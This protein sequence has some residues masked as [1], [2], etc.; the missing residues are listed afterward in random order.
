MKIL[1][2]CHE[3]PPIGG[4]Y[5]TYARRL[6][7]E[8]VKRGH[9][10]SVLTGRYKDI[11][12]DNLGGKL[13]IHTVWSSRKSKTHN[14]IIRTFT[15]YVVLGYL[16]ARKMIREERYDV[17]HAFSSIPAGFL[18]YLLKRRRGPGIVL[19]IA[20]S[21]VPYHTNLK[22]VVWLRPLIR[23][24]WR[25]MDA[26]ISSTRYLIRIAARTYPDADR[27][28]VV[29]A[30]GIHQVEGDAPQKKKDNRDRCFMLTIGRLV[31]IKGIQDV[32]QALADLKTRREVAN[33]E[34]RIVGDGPYRKQLV[35]LAQKY[36]VT[37]QVVFL[38]YVDEVKKNEEL[39]LADFLITT[40]RFDNAP[41]V[42]LEAMTYGLP[43]ITTDVGGIAEVVDET[44]GLLVKKSSI[45]E[46][47]GAI[48]TMVKNRDNFKRETIVE[49]S[50]KYNWDRVTDG[51]LE[52]YK[53]ISGNH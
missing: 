26:V 37:G 32:L 39:A 48:V 22:A 47:A 29:I 51:H 20:G 43:I 40:P 2:L 44:T 3:F 13:H 34:F 17:V 46:I 28:F 53:K 18:G 36:G 10:V 4:G 16:K 49:R 5:G 30:G 31:D 15:A 1:I 21:D 8:L 12:H 42:L 45:D 33:L 7:A 35:K 23:L 6:A 19:T 24:I 50:K 25:H 38:G 11:L 27:N 41:Y 52:L 9:R 14:N